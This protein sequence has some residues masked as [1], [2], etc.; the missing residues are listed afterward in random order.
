M[1]RQ[2]ARALSRRAFLVGGLEAVTAA[3]ASAYLPAS[4]LA[5]PAAQSPINLDF[6][7]WG[8]KVEVVQDNINQF[9]A[10]NP[11]IMVKLG[12]YPWESFHESMVNRF[13]SKTPTDVTYNGGDWLGEFAKAGWV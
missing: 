2:L 3:A 9:Q 6:V 1:T 10:K 5:A 12:D 7:V 11:S 13:R 4:S 8:Y